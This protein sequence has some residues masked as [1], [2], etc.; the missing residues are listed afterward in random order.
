MAAEEDPVHEVAAREVAPSMRA[1]AVGRVGGGIL[2]EEMVGALELAQ[3]IGVR[4][5]PAVGRKV[6]LRTPRLV[7]HVVPLAEGEH[8]GA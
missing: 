4:N 8:A 6:Q 3:A 2:A 5:G 1:V 7:A